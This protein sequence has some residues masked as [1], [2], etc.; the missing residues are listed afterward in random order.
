MRVVLDTNVV[1]SALLFERGHLAWVRD[2]W[3]KGRI[4]PLIDKPCA[5]ELVRV[6]AY[7]KFRLSADEIQVLLGD[8]LPYAETTNTAGAALGRL[9][10]CRDPHDQIFLNLA[11]AGKAR[12]L[13][14]GDSALLALSGRT[15][16][17]IE[18]PADFRR[19]G[20]I[21]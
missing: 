10:R 4:A 18:T 17:A 7:P 1:V 8:Y 14:T 12:V 11:E 19:R 15:R 16:F 3:L 9:P 21:D 13:V 5:D 6:L 20:G 2:A